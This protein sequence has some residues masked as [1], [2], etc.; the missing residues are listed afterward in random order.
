[1]SLFSFTTREVAASSAMALT[2]DI[3]DLRAEVVALL[4]NFTITA[5]GSKSGFAAL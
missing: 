3:A 1:M 4:L 5:F 2:F